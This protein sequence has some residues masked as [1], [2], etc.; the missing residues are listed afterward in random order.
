MTSIGNPWPTY[1]Y[2]FNVNLEYKGFEFNM[3]W[4][5]V[6]DRDIYN[7]TKQSLENMTADWNSASDVWNAWT[8]NNTHTSQPRLG[9]ATHNYQ[10]PNSYMVED[11]SYLRLKNIQL[12]YSFGK[13]IVSKMKLSK[14]KIYV[15]V[16]N[17][18]TFTKFK[19]F[20]P[21]F[22]GNNNAEQGVYNLTQY[23][24]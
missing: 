11:G 9:N 22:I 12:G 20:D 24:Q 16:E 23:P 7:N 17:A 2:G 1:V 3:N 8:P 18:L 5:G 14:L 15:G 21:E 10:L 6:A 13:S 4:Q 19:G